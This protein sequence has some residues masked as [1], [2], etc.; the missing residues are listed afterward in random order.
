MLSSNKKHFF[1][2]FGLFLSWLLSYLFLWPVGDFAC[3]DSIFYAY[4]IQS[5]LEEGRFL[6]PHLTSANVFVQVSLGYF[7]CKLTG[8]F[9]FDVLR[10]ITVVTAFLGSWAF[11][12][13]VRPYVRTNRLLLIS[14]ALVIFHPLYF[15]LSF[16]FMTDVYFCVGSLWSIW[17]L[18]KY[19]EKEKKVFFLWFLIIASINFMNRQVG[20]FLF[21]AAFLLFLW[22]KK[23]QPLPL[24]LLL[25]FPIGLYFLSEQLIKPS[26][27]VAEYYHNTTAILKDKF[28][29]PEWQD[30]RSFG[31]R[32]MASVLYLGFFLIPF[33]VLVAPKV[34][35]DLSV[36]KKLI[37]LAVALGGTWL[38]TFGEVF[39]PDRGNMFFNL[40]IGPQLMKDI[41]IEKQF[42]DTLYLGAWFEY[43]AIFL[44]LLSAGTLFLFFW[45]KRR[46]P[47]W[48]KPLVA[49]L[50]IFNAI[51][52]PFSFL[53]HS[54]FDRYLLFPIISLMLLFWVAFDGENSGI[55]KN[56]AL[57]LTL[58]LSIGFSLLATKD[59]FSWRK[60]QTKAFTYLSEQKIPIRQIDAGYEINIQYNARL[61]YETLPGKS[62]WFVDEDDY[63]L[64]FGPIQGYEVIHREPYFRVLTLETQDI[65]ILKK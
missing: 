62:W 64:S 6:L 10:V 53:F 47:F 61:D 2:L 50:L 55:G 59:Y 57:I 20:L 14:L 16:T 23:Y 9:S 4:P 30:I 52:I 27:G 36:K 43:P 12:L 60:A 44:A 18:N 25:L 3:I 1:I 32:S 49:Y 63:C 17:A 31:K 13:L 45:K 24:V 46:Q 26:L 11:Y 5:L 21:P 51:L 40:G 56:P 28:L 42:S 39:N 29:S 54:F 65:Y 7:F 48:K 22:E 8:S 35:K 58:I 34:W 33:A 37:F 38:G 19:L 15:F 41:F